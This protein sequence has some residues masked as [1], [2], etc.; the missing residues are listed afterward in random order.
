MNNLN[1]HNVSY[2]YPVYFSSRLPPNNNLVIFSLLAWALIRNQTI[3]QLILLLTGQT[4]CYT[5]GKHN[6]RIACFEPLESKL[7]A[8]L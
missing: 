7:N 3:A 5:K 4:F 8:T 1:I 6:A 2:L